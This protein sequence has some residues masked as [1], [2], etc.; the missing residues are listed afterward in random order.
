MNFFSKFFAF[1]LLF[2]SVFCDV[3]MLIFDFFPI[4]PCFLPSL[5]L[6]PFEALQLDYIY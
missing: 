5:T 2:D 1:V 3:S 4:A 6:K